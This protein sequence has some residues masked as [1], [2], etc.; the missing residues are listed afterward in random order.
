M[1]LFS[2]S[3]ETEFLGWDA[4]LLPLAA[5]RICEKYGTSDALDLTSLICVLPAL[6][7]ARRLEA[8]L[9]QSAAARNLPY[10]P[11]ELITVGALPERL[12][13]P[14]CPVALEFEQ[15]L[16]W[17]RALRERSPESLSP[18]LPS[19]PPPEPIGPWLELAMIL[20][21]LHEELAASGLSFGDVVAKAETETETERWNLLAEVFS[22]YQQILAT[23]TLSDPHVERQKAIIDQRC[24]INQ[25]VVLVGTSDLSDTLVAM[26]RSLPGE[27]LALIAAPQSQAARFDEF[28][29]VRTERWTDHQLPLRDDHLISAG[30]ITD[31]ASAVATSLAEV[32]AKFLPDQVTIGVTDPSHVGPVEMELR[33]CGVSTYRHSGWTVSETALGRLLSLTATHLNR[34][35]WHS[36]AGLVRHADVSDW[37]TGELIDAGL[38]KQADSVRWLTDL[39]QLLSNHFPVALNAP[40]PAAAEKAHPLACQVF[41]LVGDLLRPLQGP[42][43]PIA[44]WSEVVLNWMQTFYVRGETAQHAVAEQTPVEPEP[45]QP[46]SRTNLA[47]EAARKLVERFAGLSEQLDFSIDGATAIEMLAGRLADV[48]VLPIR[49]AGQVQIVGWL[50]LALDDSEAMTVLGL[51]HPFVPGAT[52]SDPFLPGGLRTKLRMDDNERRYARDVYAMHLMLSTRKEIRFIVGKVAADRSPT[53]P[54]RLLAAAPSEDIARRMRRLLVHG[55]Q[56]RVVGHQWDN[57]S[58]ASEGGTGIAIP[59]LDPGDDGPPVKTMSVTA[60]RDYLACP[61]RFYLRHV[62]KLKP[63]DDSMREL[64]ANQFGDLVHGALER[65]GLSSDR[66]LN[67]ALKIEACLVEHLHQYADEFYGK[68]ASTAVAL[69]VMQAEKRLKAVA[70]AQADRASDGWII[71]ASE[72]SVNET[73]GAAIEIDGRR[74]GLRG[75]FDRIDFHPDSGR[76]AILDYKT[77]G[78]RPEK[79]HLQK[80]ED[81]ERWIDLQLPLYRMMIPFLG[82]DAPPDEVGLGYFNV[83]EKDD[84]TRINLAEFSETQMAEAQRIIHECV[85]GIWDRK[86]EPTDQRV[87]F[88]DYS[89]I[90]QSGV[91]N[92]MLD[93]SESNESEEVF[94]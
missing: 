5:E 26:L 44:Q 18:V 56:S 52:T 33:G 16:G 8:L 69:Q 85:R 30:D 87:A 75:R 72:A 4:P 1:K 24:R 70:K 53:P 54:S 80:T 46:T 68:Q 64:A 13:R 40:L 31:Q 65:F 91:V 32:A 94:A 50:D 59:S 28:G 55:G 73:D 77:H 84:E 12:Y 45:D 9:V 15:T 37:V 88:D 82:I 62:L 39:D 10:Q 22:G 21:R 17:A 51:N 2:T 27:L 63:L 76:W 11:P 14:T 20:R 36:L 60:F 61:Y 38:I 81:G 6:R 29:C 79:K 67:D 66:G 71:H 47:L 41:R 58:I 7:S 19:V 92:Q 34:Q 35:T 86:F 78:H 93:E 57:H 89:M 42:N 49:Q 90:L 43:Q 74:M 83:S 3:C 25:T 48:R 23:A